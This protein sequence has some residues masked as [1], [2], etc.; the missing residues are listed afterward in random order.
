MRLE[1]LLRQTVTGH[2]DQ[3]NEVFFER[4]EAALQSTSGAKVD[5]H[6]TTWPSLGKDAADALQA[7]RSVFGGGHQKLLIFIL[8]Q[9]LTGMIGVLIWDIKH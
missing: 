5:L 9:T 1:S 6:I 2:F 7:T 8:K 4:A 3:A